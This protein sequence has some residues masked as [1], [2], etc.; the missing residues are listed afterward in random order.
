MTDVELPDTASPPTGN[1]LLQGWLVLLL[2]SIFGGGLA[3]LEL[4]LGPVIAGNKLA[5]T[6]DQIPV[7]VEG[8]T[9]T[10]S[11]E[12]T[13]G[14]NTVYRAQRGDE[15]L[16]W[17]LPGKGTGF[18]DTIE[19][20]VSVD[21]ENTTVLGI[22]VLAQKE[23]PGLGDP[24][25]KDPAFRAQYAGLTTPVSVTKSGNPTGNQI[26]ALTGATIS[27][28]AVSDI[29][30]ATVAAFDPQKAAPKSGQEEGVAP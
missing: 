6:L 26:Q 24:I 4:M 7:L 12:Y 30:N 17:V 27:S 18:A 29:V 20:L 28:Q 15:V 23:T 11:L 13:S 3:G 19:I 16:G 2:A 22:Y 1:P 9:A 5:E 8:A 25:Q 10:D 14:D 21:P